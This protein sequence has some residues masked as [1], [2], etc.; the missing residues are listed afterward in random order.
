MNFVL[1]FCIILCGIKSSHSYICA[2]VNNTTESV[3]LKCG[4]PIKDIPTASCTK[5]L[6]KSSSM[7]IKR[8][9]VQQLKLIDRWCINYDDDIDDLFANIRDFDISFTSST[10]Y[11][12]SHNIKFK[13]LEKFNVSHCKIEIILRSDFQNKLNLNEIDLSFNKIS[14]FSPNTFE[15]NVKLTMINLSNNILMHLD[16]GAFSKLSEL[17]VLD[18]S[19][20]RLEKLD[21][22][23]FRNNRKLEILRME[24]NHFKRFDCNWFL[25]VENLKSL[26]VSLDDMTEL[27]LSCDRTLVYFDWNNAS[28]VILRLP[29]VEND[30]RFKKDGFQKLE[31]FNVNGNRFQNISE[32]LNLLGTPLKI[33]D[34]SGN[35]LGN[36]E[37]KAFEKFVNLERLSLS[38]THLDAQLKVDG[39]SVTEP[40]L[41]HLA[42]SFSSLKQLKSL[43]ISKNF[44]Q[45]LNFSTLSPTLSQLTS[46][47]IANTHLKNIA[48]ILNL[49]S[50]SGLESLD[51]SQNY[52]GKIN[53]N[54]FRQFTNLQYLN[55]S[56][57]HLSNFRFGT[58]FHQSKLRILDISENE[59]KNIDFTLFTRRFNN[60]TFL[61][62]EGN[63]LTDINSVNM[64]NFPKLESLGISKN[65][66][67]CHYLLEFLGRWKN[68][69]V[70]EN[71]SDG[72]HIDGIDCFE[73]ENEK[74][75]GEGSEEQ[76]DGENNAKITNIGTLGVTIDN[77]NSELRA[78]KYLLLFLCILFCGYL[79]NKS[80]IISRMRQKLPRN[81]ESNVI[82]R[83]TTM[84]KE[85]SIGL[86]QA[87]DN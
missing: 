77:N 63:N 40:T 8:L 74:V 5:D 67:S 78:I 16:P 7:E 6:F 11:L 73:G 75:N 27:D 43:D 20:N 22:D 28:D 76:N 24:M 42:L 25:P 4:R 31:Y 51:V 29:T 2:Y 32:I 26:S 83:Q 52:V 45:N 64:L 80:N 87:M 61:N 71:P 65:Q 34:L 39:D 12:S 60:L 18:I 49:L 66:F 44:L 55:L 10:A 81:S 38:D 9:E 17:K 35:F 82:Y 46:L 3:I 85:H 72:T 62:L 70:I 23:I 86:I 13:Y 48:E 37:S 53:A 69:K 58:F 79:I 56:R 33:L 59:L 47:N 57:T 84:N 54:T 50:S 36:L 1:L 21:E 30:L 15:N 19:F 41:S 14:Q 68:L